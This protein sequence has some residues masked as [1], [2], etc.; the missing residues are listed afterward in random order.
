LSFDPL[1]LMHDCFKECLVVDTK[2]QPGKITLLDL[3]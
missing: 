2:F 3:Y 1:N